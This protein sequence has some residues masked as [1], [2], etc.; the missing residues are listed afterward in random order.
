MNQILR[1][2]WLPELPARDYVPCPARKKFSQS[3][4]ITNPLIDQAFSVKIYGLLTKCEVRMAGYSPPSSFFLACLWNE[5]VSRSINT[6]KKKSEANIQ[7]SWPNKLGQYWKDLLYGF[8]ENFSRGT[9][10]VVPR[11][12]DSSILPSGV[13]SQSQRRIWFI[14]PARGAT[15]QLRLGP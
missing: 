12:Q 2:D 5:T 10:R 6:Q 3:N 1:C 4:I 7:P 13:A 11:G 9:R 14:L 8:R 15:A